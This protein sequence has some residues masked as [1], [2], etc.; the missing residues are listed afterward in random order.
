[1]I[2]VAILNLVWYRV[3]YRP[4][5]QL[6]SQINL[7][8]RGTWACALPVKRNDEIG[9][10]TVAFNRLGEQLTSTFQQ[11]NAASKLSA[12]ALIGGRLVREV[13]AIR[14]RIG[15]GAG[16]ELAVIEQQL[17]TLETR[18]EADFEHELSTISADPGAALRRGHG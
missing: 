14:G 10:L 9:E 17:R 15:S 6:L 2:A 1:V 11:I 4:I 13:T 16:G 5:R 8:G 7:M 12:L 18:F 3:I